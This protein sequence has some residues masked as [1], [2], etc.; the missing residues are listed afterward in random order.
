MSQIRRK[1][2]DVEGL[3]TVPGVD[4][5]PAPTGFVATAGDARVSLSWNRHTLASRYHIWRSDG[6]DFNYRFLATTSNLSYPD[7]AVTNG[8]RYYY[9]LFQENANG[10]NSPPAFANARP[11]GSVTP[12]PDPP[13]SSTG[14]NLI[15]AIG[16][17]A[18]S[19]DTS[20]LRSSSNQ[21]R[22]RQLPF[23][24]YMTHAGGQISYW[25][26]GAPFNNGLRAYSLSELRNVINFNMPGRDLY[27][28]LTEGVPDY[29]NASV[30]AN[31]ITN[32]TNLL[33]VLEEQGWK[34]IV[35]DN[36]QGYGEQAVGAQSSSLLNAA[37]EAG[38]ERG[39]VFNQV[40]PSAHFFMMHGPYRYLPAG[41]PGFPQYVRGNGWNPSTV[42]RSSNR[43]F[44]GMVMTRTSGLVCD[45]GQLY[46]LYT[47]SEF[48]ASKNFRRND[49]DAYDS[50]VQEVKSKWT[51]SRILSIDHMTYP[52]NFKNG[53]INL[54]NHPAQQ[55]AALTNS[56]HM[57][58][59]YAT[60]NDG[61]PTFDLEDWMA[62]RPD[63][64]ANAIISGRVTTFVP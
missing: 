34:G 28:L 47:N 59:V 18:P 8:I 25:K 19:Y 30:R 6:N 7:Q 20:W 61:W 11:Q 46:N 17:Y 39:N 43:V 41:N 63:A 23:E 37:Y 4:Q 3:P 32:Y 13:S 2:F 29:Q 10:V 36:E 58:V 16:M 49:I 44:N 62:G 45:G 53:Q 40:Y 35:W 38:K 21:S 24:G 12:D 54:N 31:L 14:A 42:V 22:L 26:N 48:A 9:Q 1:Y 60:P 51:S 64:W 52:C 27:L 56:E 33:A 15:F 57:V 55:R 5:L 50:V